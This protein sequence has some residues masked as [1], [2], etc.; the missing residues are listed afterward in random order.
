MLR[1]NLVANKKYRQKHKQERDTTDLH[2][3]FLEKPIDE[4]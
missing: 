3:N 4:L 2:E 1:E